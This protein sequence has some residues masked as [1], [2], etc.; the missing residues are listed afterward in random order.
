MT[1]GGP[2]SEGQDKPAD[3]DLLSRLFAGPTDEDRAQIRADLL[4]RAAQVRANGWADFQ[5]L[6]STGEVIG[7]A[8][9]L[10]AHAELAAR[11]ETLQSARERWAFELWGLEAG[12][13]DVDNGCPATRQWFVDAANELNADLELR[14]LSAHAAE[15]SIVRR[16]RTLRESD[17]QHEDDAK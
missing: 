3:R 16:T 5:G 6:W 17:L 11:R 1:P 12:Q 14:E 2:S 4:A 7:V 10:E 15:S 13:A 8:V 9:L